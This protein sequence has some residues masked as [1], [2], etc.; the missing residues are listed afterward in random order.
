MRELACECHERGCVVMIQLPHL[1]RRTRW[2]RAARLRAVSPRQEREP[3]RR[4]FKKSAEDRDIARIVEDHCG[5]AGR[6]RAAG[7]DGIELRAY[8]HLIAPLQPG[9]PRAGA[10]DGNSAGLCPNPAAVYLRAMATGVNT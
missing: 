2:A 8:G 4:A 3:E 5:A 9:A 1:G 6:M 7:L 10:S